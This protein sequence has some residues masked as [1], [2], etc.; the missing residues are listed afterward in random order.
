MKFNAASALTLKQLFRGSSKYVYSDFTFNAHDEHQLDDLSISLSI[1][2]AAMIAS[3]QI[4]DRCS[5]NKLMDVRFADWCPS[6]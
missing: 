2:G 1:A 3:F 5:W 4:N 6:L